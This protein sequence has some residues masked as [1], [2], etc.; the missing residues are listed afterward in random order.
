MSTLRVIIIR[1]TKIQ[2]LLGLLLISFVGNFML[3]PDAF[4]ALSCSIATTC[5]APS[6]VI[7]RLSATSNA[8]AEL[9]TQSNYIQLVCCSGVTNLGNSCSGTFATVAKLQGATNSHI[10]QYDQTGYSNLACLSAPSGSTI[11]VANVNTP[12]GNGIASSTTFTSSGTTSW[13]VPTGVTSITVKSWGAGGAGGKSNAGVSG[14]AGGGG[15]FAQGT[16]TVTPAETLTVYVGG[17]GVASTTGAGI[18]GGGG[19][20]SAVSRGTIPTGS[21]QPSVAA[22]PQATAVAGAAVVPGWLSVGCQ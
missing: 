16:V 4:G 17:G 22:T 6:V 7:M 12:T 5:A 9:P 20:Y 10:Q 21:V 8:H 2:I 15:G 14:G 13:V 1:I 3:A 18:G 11:T 19:G